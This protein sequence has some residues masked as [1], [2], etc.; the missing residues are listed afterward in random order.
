MYVMKPS[1]L[2]AVRKT[3]LPSSV[4]QTGAFHCAFHNPLA[5]ET[6]ELRESIEV[7]LAAF[8]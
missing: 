5:D 6:D 4:N 7:R 3:D 1:F 8:Y 2:E